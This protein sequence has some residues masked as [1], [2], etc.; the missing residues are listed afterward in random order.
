METLY[1]VISVIT[2]CRDNPAQL[3][4]TLAALPA[5]VEGLVGPWEVL[6]AWAYYGHSNSQITHFFMFRGPGGPGGPKSASRPGP[7][8]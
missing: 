3:H 8:R 1:K 4:G 6:V 2:L 5:A 7:Q